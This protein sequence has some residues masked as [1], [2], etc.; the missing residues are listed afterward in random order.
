M[1]WNPVSKPPFEASKYVTYETFDYLVTDGINVGIC[2]F[3]RGGGH[4]NNPWAAW[5]EFGDIKPE[6]ITHWMQIPKPPKA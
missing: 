2:A 4:V 3:D 1:K 5:N 6:S